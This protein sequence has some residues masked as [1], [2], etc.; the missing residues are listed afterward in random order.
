MHLAPDAFL[1]GR[2]DSV[3]AHG[4]V[5]IG[6]VVDFGPAVEDAVAARTGSVSDGRGE[7]G[8]LDAGGVSGVVGACLLAPQLPGPLSLPRSADPVSAPEGRTAVDRPRRPLVQRDGLR[9]AAGE[10][11]DD[12]ATASI[13]MNDRGRWWAS[14]AHHRTNRPTERQYWRPEVDVRQQ[15]S[16]RWA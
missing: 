12:F 2:P 10:A 13:L 9:A 6:T 11:R 16:C 4:E 3:A 5:E 1:T 14:G 8:F 7:T 15:G